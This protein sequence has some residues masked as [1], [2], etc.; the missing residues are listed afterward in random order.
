M[1]RPRSVHPCQKLDSISSIINR[2]IDRENEIVSLLLVT[3][4]SVTIIFLRHRRF[5]T[6][7]ETVLMIVVVAM[8]LAVRRFVTTNMAEVM[9]A[10]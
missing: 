9:V 7:R 2:L 3:T 6:D 10:M 5:E 8:I 4:M 1:R